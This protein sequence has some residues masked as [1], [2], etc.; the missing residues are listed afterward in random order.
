MQSIIQKI[1]VINLYQKWFSL[2]VTRIF[3]GKTRNYNQSHLMKSNDLLQWNLP[4]A[5]MQ[6][7]G[8]AMNS[9]QNVA[10]SNVTIFLK[11]PPNSRHLS[12][13]EN[14]FKTRTCLVFRGF[15]VLQR[16]HVSFYKLNFKMIMKIIYFLKR[17]VHCYIHF[18]IVLI[19][20]ILK[21]F[22]CIINLNSPP[23]K[24]FDN[25]EYVVMQK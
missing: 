16:T 12:I 18:K 20:I 9:G 3:N 22:S 14:L 6:N 17:W 5:V 1:I 4:I 23:S 2:H 11:L 21:L 10:I 25:T 24:Y 15:T 8:H 19:L 13:T 7:R